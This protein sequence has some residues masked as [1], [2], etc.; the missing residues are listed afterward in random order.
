M[1]KFGDALFT[2]NIERSCALDAVRKSFL[3]FM[4]LAEEDSDSSRKGND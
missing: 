1:Q 3:F 2:Q 4:G